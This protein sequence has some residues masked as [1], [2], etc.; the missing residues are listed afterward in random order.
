[1]LLEPTCAHVLSLR[2]ST[3][4]R[5]R[6]RTQPRTWPDQGSEFLAGLWQSFQGIPIMLPFPQDFYHPSQSRGR[7]RGGSDLHVCIRK[8]EARESY[9]R[10]VAL[11]CLDDLETHSLGIPCQNELVSNLVVV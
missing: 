9:P 4:L 11:L 3:I 7:L 8:I 2:T 6:L 10:R 5:Q 1:M